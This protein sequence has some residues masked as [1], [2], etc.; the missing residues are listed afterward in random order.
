[1]Y[2]SKYCLNIFVLIITIHH[3][4]LFD[5][6]IHYCV[7]LISTYTCAGRQAHANVSRKFNTITGTN[8][9][10]GE[11]SLLSAAESTY[12]IIIYRALCVIFV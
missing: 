10:D 12:L 4:F 9:Q 6:H 3:D 1:M 7:Y 2:I 8:T 5:I 11:G